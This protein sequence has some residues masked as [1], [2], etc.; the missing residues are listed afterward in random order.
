MPQIIKNCKAPGPLYLSA[1][2][3]AELRQLNNMMGRLYQLA[4]AATAVSY[5]SAL[6]FPAAAKMSSDF[7]GSVCRPP[8]VTSADPV[9]ARQ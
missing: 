1:L 2:N 4:E 5:S 9:I 7:L 8:D 6:S 3:E